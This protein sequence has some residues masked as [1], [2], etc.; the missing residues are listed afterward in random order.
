M[1]INVSKT[2]WNSLIRLIDK[3]VFILKNKA[4]KPSEYNTARLLKNTK[5]NIIRKNNHENKKYRT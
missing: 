1:Q 4:Q 2:E 5:D 3:A